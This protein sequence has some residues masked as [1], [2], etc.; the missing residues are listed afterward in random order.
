MSVIVY[1]SINTDLIAY[2][3]HL[4]RKGE[5]LLGDTYFMA[6]GGKGANQAVSA[7]KLGAKVNMVG[8]VG[9]D[10]FGNEVI[11]QLNYYGVD[12]KNIE[13]VKNQGSGLA[14]ISVDDNGD[15][16]IIVLSGANMEFDQLDVDRTET[17]FDDAKVLLLQL[18]VPVEAD[19]AIARA[20]Y[21][22]GIK[23]ILDPAPASTL[24]DELYDVVDIITPN[25]VEIEMMVGIKPDSREDI[26]EA[27]NM[28]QHRGVNTVIVTLGSEGV[29][30]LEGS[31][32]TFM[33]TFEV[34]AID[35]VGSGDA[36]NGGLA[37]AISEGKSI[38]DALVWGSAAGALSTTRSG[39]A[40][41]MPDR[42]ELM[43]FVANNE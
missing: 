16:T 15:N 7:A 1:G 8:H 11:N 12:T 36:F 3:T 24:P 26:V 39:A 33:P 22:R 27:A 18:E 40:G 5:T 13:V 41:A 14:V 23:V 21:K 29:F 42:K 20:A 10:T 32:R 28:L 19:L 37:V 2:T 30:C 34:D 31:K 35:T 38:E 4:P 9:N 25:E 17:L 43:K 6:L